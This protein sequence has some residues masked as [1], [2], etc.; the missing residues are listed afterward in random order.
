M[1]RVALVSRF[2]ASGAN[3]LREWRNSALQGIGRKFGA[4]GVEEGALALHEA[5]G[6]IGQ[7]FGAG[8]MRQPGAF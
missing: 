6:G 2:A 5:H 1:A 8:I 7:P 3:W 4:D